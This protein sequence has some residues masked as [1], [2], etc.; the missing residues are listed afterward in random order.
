MLVLF[1]TSNKVKKLFKFYLQY[2]VWFFSATCDALLDTFT[3]LPPYP[4]ATIFLAMA[5]KII[6]I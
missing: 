5:Y 6:I 1:I 3:M 2:N 4:P